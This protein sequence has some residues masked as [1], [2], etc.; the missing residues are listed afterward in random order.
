M[1]FAMQMLVDNKENSANNV[2]AEKRLNMKVSI[3]DF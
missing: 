1:K 3:S 2:D